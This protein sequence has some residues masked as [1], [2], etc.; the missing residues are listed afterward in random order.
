MTRA[1][2]FDFDGTIADTETTLF[3]AYVELYEDHGHG[4]DRA[5]WV[6]VIGTDDSWDPLDDLEALVGPLDASVRDRRRARRD[7]L[8]HAAGVRRGV[9]RWLDDAAVL[10]IPI[11]IASS[12]PIDWVTGH[13]DRLALTDRFAC[14]ACCNELIPAKPDPTSYRLACEALG[15]TPTRS[16]AIEDSPHGVAA[17]K[18]AGL[19]TIATPH[20]LTVDLDFGRADLVV[21][22]LEDVRLADLVVDLRSARADEVEWLYSLH[23][24]A[25]EARVV[26]LFG[27]WDEV[28]QRAMWANRNPANT[29]EVVIV[30]GRRVGAVHT[31]VED[32]FEVDLIEVHPDQ[33]SAGIGGAVLRRLIARAGDLDVTLRTH[34]GSPALRLYERVGFE[35]EGESETHHLLRRRN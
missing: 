23:R 30:D 19:F 10:G 8:I 24:A 20:D 26:E 11:G 9:L 17:A 15:A 4:L 16:I 28:A 18:D 6:S 21:P 31:R 13:L 12:S 5:R 7:E 25:F 32:T 3:Q 33:Q 2:I 22:S 34:L 35:V 14:F 29:I 27:P 1:V